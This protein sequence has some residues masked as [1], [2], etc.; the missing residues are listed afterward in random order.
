MLL[1][2]SVA[3]TKKTQNGDRQCTYYC[4]LTIA[5]LE[6]DQKIA[7]MGGGDSHRVEKRASLCLASVC[8]FGGFGRFEIVGLPPQK[9][10]WREDLGWTPYFWD[11]HPGTYGCA[12]IQLLF[13]I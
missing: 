9:K 5:L 4:A 7:T 1:R 3:T 8:F 6:I 13:T 2:P 12:A 10:Y 11:F